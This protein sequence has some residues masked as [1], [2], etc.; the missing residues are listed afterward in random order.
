M[1]D[2]AAAIVDMSSE[3]VVPERSVINADFVEPP[4]AVA[5]EHTD[6]AISSHFLMRSTQLIR[7]RHSS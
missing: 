3:S 4:H 7:L 1:R 5:I 2:W 6:A